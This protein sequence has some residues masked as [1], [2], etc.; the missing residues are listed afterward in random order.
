MDKYW[1]YVYIEII[2][3]SVMSADSIK[4]NKD[5]DRLVKG[6][7]QLSKTIGVELSSNVNYLKIN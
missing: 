5:R 3:M 1:V 2:K 4:Q 6:C 7:F